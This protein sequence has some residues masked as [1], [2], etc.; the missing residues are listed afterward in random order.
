MS[1][2]PKHERQDRLSR[3]VTVPVKPRPNRP[4]QEQAGHGQGKLRPHASHAVIL[5]GDRNSGGLLPARPFPR[6]GVGREFKPEPSS[7]KAVAARLVKSRGV[8][9]GRLR[10]WTYGPVPPIPNMASE[11]W[12][13]QNRQ[14]PVTRPPAV[15]LG[16]RILGVKESQAFA[17]WQSIR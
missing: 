8:S 1:V 10:S 13:A 7:E 16:G 15:S 2:A 12:R 4:T 9:S 17:L 5:A 3:D 6:L 11:N 14:A